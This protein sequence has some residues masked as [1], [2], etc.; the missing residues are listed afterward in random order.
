MRS[1]GLAARKLHI[2]QPAL[3]RSIQRLE[4]EAGGVLFERGSR[5]VSLT[6]RGKLLLPYIRAMLAEADRANEQLQ[7]SSGRRHTR[8]SLGVSPNFSLHV[9]PD[10]IADFIAEYPDANVR[11]VSDSGEQLLAMLAGAELDIVITIAWGTTL[12]MALAKNPDIAREQIAAFSAGVFAPANHPLALRPCVGLAELA[13]QRWGVP[14]SMSI[15]YVF[16]DAF[17]N[18]GLQPPQQVINASN[19]AHMLELSQRLDL[20][21]IIP[22]HLAADAVAAGTLIP[23]DCPALEIPYKVDMLSRRR[24]TQPLGLPTFRELVRRHFHAVALDQTTTT[25]RGT[26][27]YE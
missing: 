26:A 21:L 24:G 14:H 15:S 11:T 13:S 20:L 23:L 8:I 18:E 16:R 19:A 12:Q 2:S 27:R 25:D 9:T 17:L 1:I 3:T 6:S 22:K 5:G 7:S 4:R 10:I